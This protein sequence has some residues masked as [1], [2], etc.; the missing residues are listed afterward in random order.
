MSP[1]LYPLL[2]DAPT[3]IK[4]KFVSDLTVLTTGDTNGQIHQRPDGLVEHYFY[5]QMVLPMSTFALA[6]GKWKVID[7]LTENKNILTEKTKR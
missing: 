5:T 6:I 2:R 7:I 1:P 3:I 4:K